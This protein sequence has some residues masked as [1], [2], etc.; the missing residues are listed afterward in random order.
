MIYPWLWHL[1]LCFHSLKVMYIQKSEQTRRR[2]SVSY[3]I[4]V[5]LIPL[6]QGLILNLELCWRWN[7]GSTPPVSTNP[8]VPLATTSMFQAQL[9]RPSF[10]HRNWVFDLT[11]STV[12]ENIIN[13]W[14]VSPVSAILT[15]TITLTFH[16][17]NERF[18]IQKVTGSLLGKAWS[19]LDYKFCLWYL[20]FT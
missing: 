18:L 10:L 5:C 1:T 9:C 20:L 6:W 3:Y 19:S 14:T 4:T 16:L 2:H 15:V 11:P 8:P 7:Y 13:Y 17:Y 12:T